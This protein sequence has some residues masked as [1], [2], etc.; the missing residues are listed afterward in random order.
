MNR[1][2]RGGGGLAQGGPMSSSGITADCL[3]T[4]ALPFLWTS[5]R[6]T[7]FSP[8]ASSWQIPSPRCTQRPVQ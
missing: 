4:H 1:E 5:V 8:A 2:A 7:P 6:N 3:Q